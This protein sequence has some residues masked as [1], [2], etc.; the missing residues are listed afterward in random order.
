MRDRYS[1]GHTFPDYVLPDHTQT[2]RRLSELQGDSPMLLVLIRGFRCP[3]DRAQLK[4]LTRFHAQ[5]P[6]GTLRLVV[7]TGDD[8]QSTRALRLQLDAHYPFLY[9]PEYRVR[10]DLA[11]AEPGD[12]AHQPMIPHTVLLAPRLQIHRVWN[13]HYHW[14]RPSTCELHDALRGVVLNR[15]LDWGRD[16]GAAA[17]CRRYGPRSMDDRGA[18]SQRP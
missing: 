7:I 16:G 8:W 17:N 2:E 15:R 4:E 9:D 10:D 13:G 5:W 12:G 3:Q 11:I 6:A 1:P 14:G 18:R